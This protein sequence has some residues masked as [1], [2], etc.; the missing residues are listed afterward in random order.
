MDTVRYVNN[1][2]VQKVF[3]AWEI[4]TVWIIVRQFWQ[5]FYVL[6][7]AGRFVNGNTLWWMTNEKV[8]YFT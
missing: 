2:G 7:D 5:T 6:N 4:E 3:F 1:Y 8:L